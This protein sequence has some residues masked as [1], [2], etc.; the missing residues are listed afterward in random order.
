[1]RAPAPAK[2]LPPT[3]TTPLLT[4]VYQLAS[5]AAL[6]TLAS[7]RI[8]RFPFP[9]FPLSFH[10]LFSFFSLFRSRNA[11]YSTPFFFAPTAHTPAMTQLAPLAAVNTPLLPPL[12]RSLLLLLQRS[13]LWSASPRQPPRGA[14]LRLRACPPPPPALA[15]VTARAAELASDVAAAVH[16]VELQKPFFVTS[17]SAASAGAWF[18]SAVSAL[19]SLVRFNP[20]AASWCSIALPLLHTSQHLSFSFCKE[21]NQKQAMLAVKRWRQCSE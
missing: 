3:P 7:V 15:A 16:A 8:A 13:R 10:L 9:L 2:R 1:M 20:A 6:D 4:P 11:A 17:A 19:P 18:A 21:K 5:L 14:R 12:V